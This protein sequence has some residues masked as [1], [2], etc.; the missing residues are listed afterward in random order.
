M[1]EGSMDGNDK[2]SEEEGREIKTE[3]RAR[4]GQDRAKQLQVKVSTTQ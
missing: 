2:C 4:A 1:A 3:R